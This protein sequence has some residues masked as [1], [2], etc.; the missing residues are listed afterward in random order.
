[1]VLVGLVAALCVPAPGSARPMT[2]PG[3]NGLI[4]FTAGLDLYTV[5]PDGLTLTQVTSMRG[6]EFA[7]KWSPDGKR[8]AFA[9]YRSATD[10][11]TVYIVRPD[12][13]GLRQVTKGRTYDFDISWSP[14]GRRLAYV[15]MKYGRPGIFVI[16]LR[17]G[18]VRRVTPRDVDAWSVDWSPNGRRLVYGSNSHGDADLFTIR[19]GGTGVRQLTEGP[20]EEWD[21]IWAP[22]GKSIVYTR[23]LS[24]SGGDCMRLLPYNPVVY[25]SDCDYDTWLMSADGTDQRAVTQTPGGEY[26][27]AFSPDGQFIVYTST[28]TDPFGDIAIMNVDGTQ[29]RVVSGLTASAD[30]EA[31]WQPLPAATS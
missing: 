1:M 21:A 25:Q 23:A 13:T 16:N 29:S 8:I 27:P 22:D 9:R 14:D 28:Q 6:W 2:S 7:P 30:W 17:S 4:A 18:R 24:P 5:T 11:A 15:S 26:Y 20:A 12:G 3:A 10:S 31:D 19:P